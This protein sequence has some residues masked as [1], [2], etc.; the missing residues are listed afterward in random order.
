[1]SKP[2][3]LTYE[4]ALALLERAVEERG[5]EHSTDSEG[6]V[7]QDPVG[8]PSCLVGLA[9]S[10]VGWKPGSKTINETRFFALARNIHPED[11]ILPDKAFAL[12]VS[13][14]DYQDAKMTWGS[15]LERAKADVE[16]ID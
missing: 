8:N 12:L 6:C 11:F 2:V 5:A 10:Y 16:S 3:K 15:A 13:A 1:M 4:E 7:Y 9:L 14:Q